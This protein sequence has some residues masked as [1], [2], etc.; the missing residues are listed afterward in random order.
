MQQEGSD[1]EDEELKQEYV[2]EEGVNEE[3][4][5]K[6][7]PKIS[8]FQSMAYNS[9][10]SITIACVNL[11]RYIGN[12]LQMMQILQPIAFEVFQGVI[13]LHEYYLYVLVYFFC[14]KP[15]AQVAHVQQGTTFKDLFQ[16]TSANI[17]EL[18]DEIIS[19]ESFIDGTLLPLV[20]LHFYSIVLIN[21]FLALSDQQLKAEFTRI[22][23]NIFGSEKP[24]AVVSQL[25]SLSTEIDIHSSNSM[26]GL[27]HRTV[28][29]DSLQFL[30]NC[31]NCLKPSI[32]KILPRNHAEVLF[33]P[34]YTSFL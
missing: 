15:P 28:A 2:A 7:K 30:A 10:T 14:K 31:L 32:L 13:Q 26:Y 29:V 27:N 21:F 24:S 11:I 8:K 12:Y 17:K 22:H 4:K 20:F 5:L 34:F 25:P 19:S 1:D 18:T 16:R 9:V 3:L 33:P 6:Q 23:T